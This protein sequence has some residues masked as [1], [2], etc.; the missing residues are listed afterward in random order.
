MKKE[1]AELI[2][3]NP[4]FQTLVHQRTRTNWRMALTVIVVYFTFI[5]LI[6]YYPQLLAMKVSAGSEISVGLVAGF[7]IIVFAFLMT[8]LY[9]RKANATFDALT[10][11]IKESAQ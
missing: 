5:L 9:V 4:D 7:L 1:L 2:Q 8:G 10:A 3:S 6:A 11:R